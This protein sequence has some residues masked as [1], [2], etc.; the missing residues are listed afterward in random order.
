MGNLNRGSASSPGS[1][2]Q[3]SGVQVAAGLGP[4]RAWASSVPSLL[5]LVALAAR[6]VPWL[7]APSLCLPVVIMGLLPCL[8]PH[9]PLTVTPSGPG[10]RPLL[11]GDC[12][13]TGDACRDPAPDEAVQPIPG[14][15]LRVGVC[16][17][18]QPSLP[19]PA[20]QCPLRWAS[21]PQVGAQ[22]PCCWQML[23]CAW[24]CQPTRS[25]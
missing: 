25:G 8:C 13:L 24:K 12:V 11:W 6:G 3:L 14:P 20:S 10:F 22:R 9:S 5:A 19:A 1:A 15:R 7:T 23:P 4:P 18:C 2:D 21:P 16:S 17:G